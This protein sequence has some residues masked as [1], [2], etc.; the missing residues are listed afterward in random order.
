MKKIPKFASE[1]DER[2]FWQTHDSADYLDWKSAER[3]TLSKLK[4]G[5]EV[6]NRKWWL[7]LLFGFRRFKRGEARC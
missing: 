7:A 5:F 2:R 4:T 3:V 6:L 1:A